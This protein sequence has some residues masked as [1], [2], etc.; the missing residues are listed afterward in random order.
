M[1]WY[2]KQIALLSSDILVFHEWFSGL[3]GRLVEYGQ[4]SHMQSREIKA[5]Q[6]EI[7]KLKEPKAGQTWLIEYKG[8]EHI[9]SVCYRANV[10]DYVRGL[11]V[12]V[13]EAYI[14]ITNI[15]FITQI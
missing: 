7:A 10:Y 13:E 9:C 3:K 12:Y 5:L 2:K 15:R 6:Y 8:K 4:L 1:M 11:Q 14:E